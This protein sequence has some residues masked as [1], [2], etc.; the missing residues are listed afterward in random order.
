MTQARDGA[1]P[2]DNAHD[3]AQLHQGH[4]VETCQYG[5]GR[6]K[7]GRQPHSARDSRTAPAT[8]LN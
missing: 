7:D 5:K 2:E 3:G 1:R 4:I 6:E 8:I